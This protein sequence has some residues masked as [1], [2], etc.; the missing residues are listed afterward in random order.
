MKKNKK[1][2][3]KENTIEKSYKVIVIE[4]DEGLNFLI[5]KRLTREGFQVD[6]AENGKEALNK[7]TGEPTEVLLIDYKLPDMSGKELIEKLVQNFNKPP[8]FIS[9]TGF[10][11]EKIAVELMK[12][13]AKDYIVKEADFIDVLPEKLKQICQTIE[14]TRKLEEAEEKLQ[15]QSQ[16][17]EETGQMAKV[18]GWELNLDNYTVIFSEITKVIH[19]VPSDYI[20]SLQEA[21]N[22]Y[23]PK[24]RPTIENAVKKAIKKGISYDL[25]VPFITEKGHNIW[26]NTIGKPEMKEGKCIRLHGTLQDITTR[27]RYEKQLLEL[28]SQLSLAQ[29]I[30]KIG[31]WSYDVKTQIPQWTDDCFRMY[32]IPKEKGEPNFQEQKKYIHPD[33]W[34]LYYSSVQK[35]ISDDVPYDVQIRL[36]H[37]NGNIVW[38]RTKGFSG[39]NEKGKVTE[40]YGI[41]QDITDLKKT[42]LALQKAKEKAEKNEYELKKAQKLSH[43]GSWQYNV[44]TQKPEWSEEM[45]RIWGLEKQEQIE[46]YQQHKKYIHPEDWDKFD[47]TVNDTLNNGKAYNIEL[48][49][50]R[51]SGEE[52]TIITIGEPVFDGKGRITSLRGTNQDI[53]ER[54]RIE[55]E[56]IAAKEKAEE[57]DRLKSAFLANMSHEI[58]TPMNGILGFTNLLQEPNLSGEEQQ[59]YIDIIQKSGDRM[60][61]T[62]NDIINISKIEAGLVELSLSK[63]NINERLKYFCAFFKPEAEKKGIQLNL[64]NEVSEQDITIKTDLE[65]FNSILTNLIKN[66]VKFT[67]QGFIELAC[68]IKKDKGFAELE[69]YVKDSGIGIPRNRLTAI[70]E[71][72]VQA[73]IEDK[74]AMQGSGLGLAISKAYAEMLG[75]KIWVESETGLGSVFHFTIPYV[76]KEERESVIDHRITT[77]NGNT[78][79][80]KKLNIVIAEDDMTSA[81]LLKLAIKSLAQ[82]VFVTRTGTET[83]E[84]CRN[85][86]DIDLVLMDI[87]MPGMNGYEATQRIR[88]FNKEVIIIAQ[89][90]FALAGDENKSIK[91]GCNDYITKPIDKDKLL[92]KIRTLL[93]TES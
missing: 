39:K 82:K 28:N 92:E 86:P 41:V 62:V 35:A 58:R 12:L 27:K 46:N 23:L 36:V 67:D 71:R 38:M 31:Y 17:L 73:D 83:V 43:V 64:K 66:A 89:T 5:R 91:V 4:D 45:L 9:M 48:R 20:P 55:N 79:K 21:I 70:F 51:P 63:V 90:A 15:K 77:K 13:G 30:A 84:V 40:L 93:K 6:W 52:R 7:I 76:I 72:F 47:A 42:E 22:F 81:M 1:N 44:K 88:E 57:A 24:A 2:I 59:N 60:L 61:D 11:D 10:G 74:K 49:I 25:E 85:N 68:N 29:N 65:K 78:G 54:K 56:L 80:F 3:P 37:N 18:G 33:D 26:V 34:D 69:F 87:Q 75:G 14:T 32:N 8:H 50:I 19:E 53:T 16:L